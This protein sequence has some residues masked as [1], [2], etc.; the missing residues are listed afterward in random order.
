MVP[1]STA[2][3]AAP[4]RYRERFAIDFD[5]DE[6][7]STRK[8][9][10]T[11][12]ARVLAV[13]SQSIQDWSHSKRWPLAAYKALIEHFA[14]DEANKYELR[15]TVEERRTGTAVPA[16]MHTL[17]T[18]YEHR[19]AGAKIALR[20]GNGYYQIPP[21]VALPAPANVLAL[22]AEPVESPPPS[23]TEAD[24]LAQQEVL[25]DLL[26]RVS[27]ERNE[28][29]V[30]LA[31]S[32]QRLRDRDATIAAKDAQILTLQ[33]TVKE[34]EELASVDKGQVYSGREIADVVVSRVADLLKSRGVP[35]LAVE[36]D[37]FSP[38]RGHRH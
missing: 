35:Q 2:G 8:L 31:R 17:A 1:P 9:R 15:C 25:L 28:Q 3:S 13:T 26:S 16:A 36:L 20:S 38:Q 12:I 7:L 18:A 10:K 32:A 21:E 6:F 4:A 30:L 23:S 11:E 33:R 34:W 14:P 5:L 37:R 27:H 19:R 22:V 29:A 24:L